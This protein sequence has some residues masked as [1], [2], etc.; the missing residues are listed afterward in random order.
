MSIAALLLFLS[1]RCHT[2]T[3]D[4]TEDTTRRLSLYGTALQKCDRPAYFAASNIQDPRYPHTGYS[5]DD[6]C[7]SMSG[8]AGS[9]YVCVSLPSDVTSSGETYSPFWTKTGQAASPNQASTWPKP[10]PWCICMWA[11]A[12][13]YGQHPEFTAMVECKATNYWVVQNYDLANANECRALQALCQHCNLTSAELTVRASIVTKCEM[14]QKVCPGSADPQK[15]S[16]HGGGG[17]E[18]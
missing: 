16:M 18:L 4:E 6:F 10:G 15:C 3:A 7:G 14:A 11:F 17:C 1:Q 2:A 9:H 8:D 13:M 5:R 12:R